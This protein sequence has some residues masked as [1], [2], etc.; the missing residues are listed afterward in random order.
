M[1]TTG[2]FN[3]YYYPIEF[4]WYGEPIYIIPF[5]DI[6]RHTDKCDEY[7][8]REFLEWA[9]DKERAYFIGMGDYDD[10]ASASERSI[11]RKSDLHE[12]TRSTLESI[13]AN[14]TDD[15]ISELGFM[16]GRCIGL[17]EGNHYGEFEDGT[18]T[19]QRMC[20]SLGCKYLG[21][22][23]LVRLSLAQRARKNKSLAVDMWLHHGTGAARMIGGSLNRV[24]NMADYAECDICLMGHDHKKS[25]GYL[26]K[27]RLRGQGKHI[28]LGS[29]RVL[30]ARTGAFLR[31]YV[32]GK[33]SYIADNAMRPTDLGVIKIELTPKRDQ[34]EGRD[35]EYVDIHASI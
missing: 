8:W 19:T 25:V 28:H 14:F 22:S 29:R 21:V 33:P 2:V 7:K 5:G 26:S 31:G 12:T 4:E 23:A 3:T 17:L 32:D 1:R 35:R 30:I 24:E 11:F 27:M 6:H 16:K 15:L 20:R 9:K 18:T 13:Y 34:R 10:L